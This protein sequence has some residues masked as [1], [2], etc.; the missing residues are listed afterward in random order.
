[1]RVVLFNGSPRPDG[2]TALLL[3]A[4]AAELEKAGVRTEHVQVGGRA[5]RGCVACFRCAETTDRKCAL[6]D[7][8]VNGWIGKMAEADGIV[9]GSPVYFGTVTA[10][11]KA[12]ID[13]C[14]MTCRM[15]DNL[16]R[17]KVGAAV[18]VARRA[19]GMFTF[20]T[21]NH[22]FTISEMVIPGSSYWNVAYG[23]EKEDV[24]GDEEG[25]DTMR[26]LG[27]NMAWLLGKLTA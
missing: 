19:G 1:M 27:E 12:L 24:A 5:V 15:N 3:Q 13:R 21:L 18:A 10:E 22:F 6:P 26:R 4:V 16:L 8:G 23:L 9:L 11:M 25:M 20:D 17:R 14:G 7:D 2:N